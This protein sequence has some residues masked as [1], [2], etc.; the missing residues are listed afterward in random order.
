[1]ASLLSSPEEYA[2]QDYKNAV[3]H[4]NHAKGLVLNESIQRQLFG[5]WIYISQKSQ[6][7]NAVLN[8]EKRTKT[9]ADLYQKQD[10][11]ESILDSMKTVV[12]LADGESPE[13]VRSDKKEI[14]E[15]VKM[16]NS[17]VASQEFKNE[18]HNAT[19]F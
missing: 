14:E 12:D 6:H 15:K 7:K 19:S 1:M 18:Q 13:K 3:E 5:L 9:R 16:Q 4:I 8:Y 11:L 10:G 17:E 2:M